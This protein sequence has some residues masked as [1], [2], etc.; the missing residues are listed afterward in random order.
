MSKL[1]KKWE[2]RLVRAGLGVYQ[3]MTDNSEGE[4]ADASSFKIKRGVSPDHA[5]L[6]ESIDGGDQFMNAFQVTKVRK[7]I[8]REIPEWAMS[9]ERVQKI[10]LTAFPTLHRTKASRAK[11]ARWARFIYLYFRMGQPQQIVMKEM[12]LTGPAFKT[13]HQRIKAIAETGVARPRNQNATSRT[14]DV[15]LEKKGD[16]T[17]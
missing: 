3:P 6:R 4:L 9:N 2:K 14:A 5:R 11:A 15:V 7:K 1:E 12:N 8:E 16:E 17:K 10:L 13:I